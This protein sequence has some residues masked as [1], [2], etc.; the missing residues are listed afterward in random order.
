MGKNTANGA[1]LPPGFVWGGRQTRTYPPGRKVGFRPLAKNT[2]PS[3]GLD[4]RIGLFS[5]TE[6]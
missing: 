2:D 5:R 6:N 1:D 4:E 3:A